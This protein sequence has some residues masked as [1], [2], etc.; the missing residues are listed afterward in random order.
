MIGGHNVIYALIVKHSFDP[1][2][3]ILDLNHY[4]DFSY[5]TLNFDH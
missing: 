4:S 5:W 3:K 2:L 1:K